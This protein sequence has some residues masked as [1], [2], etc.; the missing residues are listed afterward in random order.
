MAFQIG[1]ASHPLNVTEESMMTSP[2]ER[3]CTRKLAAA[4]SVGLLLMAVASCSR[5][6]SSKSGE[7][8]VGYSAGALDNPFA[9][10]LSKLVVQKSRAGGLNMLSA[11]NA[12]GDPAKQVSDLNALIGRG[13][14]GIVLHPRDSD[15][16]VPAIKAANK[17]HVPVITVDTAANGGDI[18]VQ[19]RAD[20]VAMGESAC[21]EIGR[22]TGGSGTVLELFGSLTTTAGAERHKGF[23]DCMAA[24]FPGVRVIGKNTN[25][26]T[27]TA[28]DTAQTVMSTSNIKAVFMASDS[29]MV[30]AV[31]KVMRNL[32]QWKPIGQP[33]HVGVVTIDGSAESLDAVRAHYVDSVVSQPIDQ[34]GSLAAQY[35]KQAVAGDTLKPGPTDHDSEIVERNGNLEDVLPSPVVTITNA[36]D[37][38]LWGNAS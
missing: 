14:K 28:A 34:Y 12:G 15:A 13:A 8:T 4:A 27:A 2:F 5:G 25:W 22:L 9:V 7:T 35:L 17:A 36:D 21:K 29:V 1:S 26:N 24:D 37:P 19:I 10:R 3:T 30:S 11:V 18:Y 33:G 32:G 16:I 20:N 6:A 38:T 31:Q 23:T